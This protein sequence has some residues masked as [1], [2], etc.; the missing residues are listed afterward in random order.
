MTGRGRVGEWGMGL[1]DR[2]ESF[3]LSDA[4]PHLHSPE[5]SRHVTL[6]H[7]VDA[8]CCMGWVTH[9]AVTARITRE[10]ESEPGY[11]RI[12]ARILPRPWNRDLHGIHCPP[13]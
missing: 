5:P 8:C 4:S 1:T 10:I 7:Q 11:R 13:V 2:V 3:P 12:V 6:P 9:R